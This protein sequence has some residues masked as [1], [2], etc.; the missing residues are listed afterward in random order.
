MPLSRKRVIIKGKGEEVFVTGGRVN[1]ATHIEKPEH[2]PV[3]V[4]S[5]RKKKSGILTLKCKAVIAVS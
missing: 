2:K 4:V 3:N 5:D 1:S